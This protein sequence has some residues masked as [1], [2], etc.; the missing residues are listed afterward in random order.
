MCVHGAIDSKFINHVSCIG[1]ESA[2][3]GLKHQHTMRI[4]PKIGKHWQNC[5][6]NSIVVFMVQLIPSFSSISVCGYID[7]L[8]VI[9][10]CAKVGTLTTAT[11]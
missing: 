10:F 2:I 3:G 6:R 11:P 7:V 4:T 8:A 9:Q 1:V 5:F